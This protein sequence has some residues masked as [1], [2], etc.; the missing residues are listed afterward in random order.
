MEEGIDDVD[1]DT[2]AYASAKMIRVADGR[3]FPLY[4]VLMEMFSSMPIREYFFRR[5]VKLDPSV[6]HF[7]GSSHRR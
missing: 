6:G 7:K 1:V 2:S 5:V 4:N 3:E